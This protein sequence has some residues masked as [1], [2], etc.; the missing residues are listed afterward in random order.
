MTLYDMLVAPFVEFSFMRRALVAC[1]AQALGCA[2]VGVLLVL[3]RMS[4]MGDAMSHAI[5]PGAAVGFMVAGLSLPAMSVG[6]LLAGLLVALGAGWVSRYTRLKEDASFA[7][8]YLLAL[9]VGVLLVSRWGSTIDLMH[10]LFGSVLAVDDPALL[11]MAGVATLTLVFMALCYRPLLLDMFDPE[12]L[13][14][15][16]HHGAFY[17]FA[18][19]ALVVINLVASFQSLGTLMA[20]GLMMLPATTARLWARTLGGLFAV[21]VGVALLAG[22][23]GLLWSYH[24][25]L[26]SGPAIILTAGMLYVMS[27]LCGRHGGLLARWWHRRHLAA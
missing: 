24:A 14:S 13:R 6:G 4:L 11:L 18:F 8:F 22:W 16:G 3:R 25:N 27:L 1:L 20:V 9:A 2:P 5:L 23:L 19:L 12:F 17:H 10:F 21:A 7:A 15:M 26:P